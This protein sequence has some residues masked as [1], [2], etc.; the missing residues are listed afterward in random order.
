MGK[1]GLLHKTHR[2]HVVVILHSA[3]CPPRARRQR[4]SPRPTIGGPLF[5]GHSRAVFCAAY[6]CVCVRARVCV[7]VGVLPPVCPPRRWVHT[8]ADRPSSRRA[9]R[10]WSVRAQGAMADAMADSSNTPDGYG[11]GQPHKHARADGGPQW[12]PHGARGGNGGGLSRVGEG[13]GCGDARARAR[14]DGGSRTC[15]HLLIQSAAAALHKLYRVHTLGHWGVHC[16]PHLQRFHTGPR[17]AFTSQSANQ[18]SN[19]TEPTR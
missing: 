16:D 11:G 19:Q 1:R 8:P 17:A 4:P 13:G 18:A 2:V 6:V 14:V 3:P 15:G 10:A 9:S 7:C 5:R 12:C